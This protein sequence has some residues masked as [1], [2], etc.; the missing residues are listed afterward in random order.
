MYEIFER[1]NRTEFV[2]ML[3]WPDEAAKEAAWKSP[4]AFASGAR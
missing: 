2:Y 3:S 4:H 1:N